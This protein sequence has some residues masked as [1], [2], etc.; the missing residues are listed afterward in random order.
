M[1]P[2]P[3]A[4]VSRRWEARL[5]GERILVIDDSEEI[6]SIL[7][8]MI[9]GPQGYEVV[10]AQDGQ[11]GIDYALK[12]HPDLILTDVSM[13]RMDGIEVLQRLR[14]AQYQW[15]IVLMTFHGSEE[16][17]I[18]AF[19]LG[20]RDYIRKPFTVEEVLTCVERALIES[21]LRR[22][23]E[24]LLR[25]LES[26]NRQLNRRVA[27]LTALYAIGQ[28]VT[29]VLDLDKLLNRIVEASVYLCRAEA[30]ALYL[31][32]KESGDLYMKASLSGGDKGAHSARLKVEN[33]LVV[34]ALRTGRSA[35]LT[36]ESP[37]ADLKVREGNTAY[38]L[39]N[40]PLLVKSEVTGVLSVANRAQRRSF[41][42]ADVTRL[43][44][45]A[46]Y[47]AI[48][49]E[50]ARL[51]EATRKVVAAE[52]LNHTV[53]TISHYIN[54]PLMALMMNIDEL[55][56][57][58]Q[59]GGAGDVG[60][61][62]E[63]AARFTRMKVEEISSVI[64]ILRDIASPQFVTYMDDIK[65]LDIEHKVQERLHYLRDKYQA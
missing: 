53:V 28:A 18:Q 61:Q 6:R 54:N 56:H 45:L 2:G 11:E 9:L 38:A 48:A 41:S 14:D 15:P 3:Q 60:E 26:A 52:V 35:L 25:R 46:N 43:T 62:V 36:S 30:G 27:E 58:C 29:A 4:Q 7:R 64:S 39:V 50:N 57:N 17:A 1:D 22:E 40:V 65:M 49:I 63:E 10:T 47:A 59:N 37:N 24:A 12:E 44:G 51:Y 21:R 20:V 19:R 31:V 34:D 8:E 13:P 23:R 5:A 16:I 42:K 32:D 33:G 55:V